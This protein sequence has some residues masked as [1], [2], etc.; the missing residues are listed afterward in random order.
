MPGIADMSMVAIADGPAW[1]HATCAA[2]AVTG[3]TSRAKTAMRAR[4]KRIAVRVF[5]LGV[6]I[7]SHRHCLPALLQDVSR[8]GCA[9]RGRRSAYQPRQREQNGQDR[10][11]DQDLHAH[12]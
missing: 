12:R 10:K 4:T 6:K 9:G 5:A 11:I 8:R 3:L 2:A 1:S 7:H